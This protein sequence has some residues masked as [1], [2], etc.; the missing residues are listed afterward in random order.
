MTKLFSNYEWKLYKPKVGSTKR[1]QPRSASPN[2]GK[3]GYLDLHLCVI[4]ELVDLIEA[5]AQAN[6][7]TGIHTILVSD[8]AYIRLKDF[9]WKFKVEEEY[10]V[11]TGVTLKEEKEMKRG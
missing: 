6:Q 11:V 2:I 3:L 9:D 1:I 10:K 5:A 8:D 7:L 4:P